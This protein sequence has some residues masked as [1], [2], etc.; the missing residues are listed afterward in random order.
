MKKNLVDKLLD[1]VPLSNELKHVIGDNVDFT[2]EL[3]TQI[4]GQRDKIKEEVMNSISR[5]VAKYL[6]KIDLKELA[7]EVLEEVD[8]NIS[9]SFK[10]KLNKK[11][12]KQD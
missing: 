9:I 1:K 7:K 6:K 5:E 8:V 2:R 11:N 10:K 3:V 4:Y 12:M